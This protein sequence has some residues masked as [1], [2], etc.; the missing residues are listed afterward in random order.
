MILHDYLLS[1]ESKEA[2]K[3]VIP[4]W[5]ESEEPYASQTHAG[6]LQIDLIDSNN[7]SIGG[8]SLMI[9]TPSIDDSLFSLKSCIVELLRPLEPTQV[10][11]CVQRAKENWKTFSF[12]EPQPYGSNYI[13]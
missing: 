10:D 4:E 6:I 2:A 11:Q 5:F 9:T 3:A 8:Y 1:F 12:P 7:V 13:W